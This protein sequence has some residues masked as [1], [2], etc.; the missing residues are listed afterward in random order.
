MTAVRGVMFPCAADAMAMA[1]GLLRWWVVSD[2]RTTMFAG[3]RHGAELRA[4]MHPAD[5]ALTLA[6]GAVGDAS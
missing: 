4:S 1:A 2:I 5:A 3:D 6:A